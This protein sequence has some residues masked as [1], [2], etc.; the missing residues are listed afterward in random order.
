M[1]GV[2]L[3]FSYLVNGGAPYGDFQPFFER[4]KT[5][6]VESVELRAVSRNTAPE[7]VLKAASLL[8]DAG[9][10]ITV[11]GGAKSPETAL[12]DL[13]RPLSLLLPSL[14]QKE[15]IVVMH[16][17]VGSEDAILGMLKALADHIKERSLPVRIALENNRKMP[18][19]SMGD[20]L[21]LVTRLVTKLDRPEVGICFDMGHYFWAVGE[22]RSKLPPK[23]FLQRVIHTHIHALHNGSTHFPLGRYDLP[24]REYAAS[25]AEG[26]GGR[27]NLELE[28]E[29]YKDLVPAADAMFESIETLKASL[30]LFS[31]LY[32]DVRRHFTERLWKAARVFDCPED[33]TAVSLIHST[34]YLFSTNDYHWAM[35]V[36]LRDGNRFSDAG[37]HLAE[38]LESVKLMVITHDHGDH[39][40]PETVEHI[41]DLPMTWL[42]PD[43]L[44]DR[45]LL[46]GLA[47]ERLVTIAA[48]EEKKIGPLTIKAFQGQHFRPGTRTGAEELGFIITAENAPKLVFPADVRDFE[49]KDLP[50]CDASDVVF[51][52]VWLGDED[53]RILDRGDFPRKFARFMTHF[54]PKKI[55]YT[56]LYETARNDQQTWRYVHAG[57]AA[58]EVKKLDPAIEADIPRMGEVLYL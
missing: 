26:Y 9:F 29:R 18:D 21:G 35:D 32:D 6:G 8:W 3:P 51:A 45:A 36:A 17:T 37:E 46:F 19:G 47:P 30:P 12:D 31:P 23:A 15:L 24:I 16:P 43:F 13:F 56:H 57:L 39:F 40:E 44:Y 55:L 20:S 1:I 53:T 28:Y 14:R 49:T 34:S 22:D 38:V 41:R 11:H 4:L 48:G 7:D 58:D 2:S 50:A 54:H 52:H 5:S 27:F 42:I 10:V 33:V 25:F